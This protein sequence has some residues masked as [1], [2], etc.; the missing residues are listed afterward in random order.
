[1]D[2]L[3]TAEGPLPEATDDDDQEMRKN[4]RLF[5]MV[6][7]TG[8]CCENLVEGISQYSSQRQDEPSI[9]KE[10]DVTPTF[11]KPEATDAPETNQ[12]DK[13]SSFLGQLSG[14]GKM[15]LSTD[16]SMG[17]SFLKSLLSAGP[18]ATTR[19]SQPDQE[20]PPETPTRKPQRPKQN[21]SISLLGGSKERNAEET[22]IVKNL[23]SKRNESPVASSYDVATLPTISS[24]I[25]NTDDSIV[26]VIDNSPDFESG[27]EI[28]T[29]PVVETT[30]KRL[31]FGR[32]TTVVTTLSGSRYRLI[33][34]GEIAS[35]GTK[36]EDLF[37]GAS[38]KSAPGFELDQYDS[39]DD[40]KGLPPLSLSSLLRKRPTETIP[41]KVPGVIEKKERIP[42]VAEAFSVLFRK[43]S[44]E[45]I[46]IQ[47]P[48]VGA[49]KFKTPSAAEAIS[50]LFKKNDTETAPIPES[51]RVEERGKTPNVADAFSSLF[52]IDT[53]DTIARPE[54]EV[55]EEKVKT[56]SV[57]ET[58]SALFK[59]NRTDSFAEPE[60]SV[61]K[62]KPPSAVEAISA[63]FKKNNTGT[64]PLTKPEVVKETVKKSSAGDVMQ[65]LFQRSGST[66]SDSIVEGERTTIPSNDL[67]SGSPKSG[68]AFTP[69]FGKK[70]VSRVAIL[71][72]WEQNPDGSITG[73]VSNREGFEDGT[74]ITTSKVTSKPQSGRIVRTSGGS[75]YRL[76]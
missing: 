1:M 57:S 17:I 9:E 60:V 27:T 69:F 5:F 6:S 58:F 65:A 13:I 53:F 10:N 18:S 61:E 22:S 56:P 55:T 33:G 25:R 62:M 49:E 34:E 66:K 72:E 45:T 73:R 43:N 21:P 16:E 24:W 32:K 37:K 38:L 54:P 74:W 46:P 20:V 14:L 50:F 4:K 2:S 64:I 51:E 28:W 68:N 35:P 59:I 36:L 44:T 67:T 63:L 30:T 12:D 41:A 76:E 39:D 42:S 47:E 7:H 29:A 31:G 52:K 3:R 8:V 26:G 71:S 40:K 23:E 11:T 19:T 75:R 70:R 48:E 15:R